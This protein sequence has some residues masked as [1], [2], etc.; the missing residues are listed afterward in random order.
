MTN[1]EGEMQLVSMSKLSDF[2]SD[3]SAIRWVSWP[4]V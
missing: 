4:S 1:V 2:L 3:W